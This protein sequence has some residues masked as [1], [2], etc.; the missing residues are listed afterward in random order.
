[1]NMNALWALDIIIA[2]GMIIIVTAVI[3]LG[4]TIALFSRSISGVLEDVAQRTVDLESE[5]I[6]L[7]QATERTE[8]HADHLLEQL[9]Q[10]ASSAGTAVRSVPPRGSQTGLRPSAVLSTA[11]SI[12]SAYRFFKSVFIR[13]RS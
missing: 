10:L 1:M 4:R 9:A 3:I 2:V 7:M 13:R 8:R 5:A 11:A 6:R 12:V